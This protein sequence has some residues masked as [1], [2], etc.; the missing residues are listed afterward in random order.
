MAGSVWTLINAS[1]GISSG[2]MSCISPYDLVMDIDAD[3]SSGREGPSDDDNWPS[4][5]AHK[6]VRT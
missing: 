2:V 6:Q 5:E 4:A 1:Y 3:A